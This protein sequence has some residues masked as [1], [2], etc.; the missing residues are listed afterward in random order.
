[1]VLHPMMLFLLQ[2]LWF[3]YDSGDLH[4]FVFESEQLQLVTFGL[5]S[6]NLS[7]RHMWDE[8]T[9]Y[10]FCLS[11]VRCRR[12]SYNFRIVVSNILARDVGTLHINMLFKLRLTPNYKSVSLLIVCWSSVGSIHG[13]ESEGS[14]FNASIQK[15]AH[16]ILSGISQE[17]RGNVM[18]N[19]APSTFSMDVKRKG[20]V[21]VTDV[22]INR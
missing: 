10:F 7:L 9:K 2:T 21:V 8:R 12:A 3:S 4:E 18:L 13:S 15:L 14:R 6:L 5:G 11:V 17:Y 1:M 19:W 16:I 20:W 22:D